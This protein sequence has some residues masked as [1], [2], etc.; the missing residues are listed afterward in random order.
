MYAAPLEGTD[1]KK[2][3]PTI[4]QRS[5]KS[6]TLRSARPRDDFGQIVKYPSHLAVPREEPGKNG[7]MTAAYINNPFKAREVVRRQKCWQAL[8]RPRC[9]GGMKH[10]SIR[11]MR[12]D[13]LEKPLTIQSTESAR[14]CPH[15][16]EKVACRAP[17]KVSAQH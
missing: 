12:L 5:V 2:S 10:R 8:R 17:D 3:P 13:P 1:A 11:R 6:G 4:S 9:H 15:R 16:F 7:S 14:A